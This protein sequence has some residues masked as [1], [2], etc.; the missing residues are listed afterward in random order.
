MWYQPGHQALNIKSINTLTGHQA[1]NIKSINTLTGHQA[2]NANSKQ[3]REKKTQERET[4]YVVT[5]QLARRVCLLAVA[6][7]D[8]QLYEN[9][10]V[11]SQK[12][13]FSSTQTTNLIGNLTYDKSA[14]W[15]PIITLIHQII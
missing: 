2:L 13:K 4:G 11:F 12:P 10:P 6:S 8:R 15:T 3:K 9:R 14:T 1:L 5:V 7:C